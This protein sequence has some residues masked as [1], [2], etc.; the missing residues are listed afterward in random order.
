LGSGELTVLDGLGARR[1]SVEIAAAA[2]DA[3]V[4]AGR[5]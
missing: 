3:R 1:W 4:L 2:H 5:A